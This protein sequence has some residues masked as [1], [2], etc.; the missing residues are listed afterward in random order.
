MQRDV[1]VTDMIFRKEVYLTRDMDEYNRAKD[2]LADQGIEYTSKSNPMTNPGRYHGTPF[3]EASA[4]YEY[5]LFVAR[6][7]EKRA[8]RALYSAG[9]K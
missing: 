3:I 2:V 6:K 9:V 8:E 7:D 4:A 5:H 1:E